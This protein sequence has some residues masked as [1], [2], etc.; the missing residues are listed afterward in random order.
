MAITL[1]DVA[2]LC[3]VHPSTVSRVLRGKE[4]IKVSDE[5]RKKIFATAQKLH[6]QPDQTARSLRLKKSNAV[7][8]V[9]PNIS[10][11]YFS[12]IAKIIDMECSNAGYT[13]VVCDTNEDQKKEI[14]AINDLCSR[15]IDGLIIAPVQ[16]SDYHIRDL[17]EKKFPFV[18]IDRCFNDFKTNAVISNDEESAY[19]AVMHLADLGHS[20][21][22]FICGRVNLY[23]V[24]KRLDGYKKALRA[25]NLG[26]NSEY[27]SGGRG[28]LESGY[29]SM[30][31]LLTL[32]KAPTAFIIS[33][34]IITLGAIKALIEMGLMIPEDISIIGFTDTIYAPYLVWPITTISHQVQKIGQESFNIL[35]NQME[36][37]QLVRLK[38][39]VIGLRFNDRESTRK[40]SLNLQ[41]VEH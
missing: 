6:Y 7:G 33:G 11:P 24:L 32:P 26:S 39:V 2:S 38:Q 15:G 37:K 10:S 21:I 23:P 12:G 14:R 9:I 28:S 13:L 20:N 5:T 31:Q 29:N 3:H 30:Q 41:K 25:H 19:Q 22:G 40:I 4:N 8:L 16:E 35:F 17:V 27:I 34:T 1:K 18:I 36:S